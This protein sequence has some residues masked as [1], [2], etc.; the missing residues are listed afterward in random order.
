MCLGIPGQITSIDPNEAEYG[1]VDVSGVKRRVCLS[2]VAEDG[3]TDHLIGKWVLVHVGFAMSLLDE[4]E[5]A[6]TL[7]AL[8]ELGEA[9]E[10]IDA[11]RAS[12]D[13]LEASS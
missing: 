10:E 3:R 13:M 12:N 4:E 8:E 5:A 2:C 9:M 7:K 11:I 1:I 6:A